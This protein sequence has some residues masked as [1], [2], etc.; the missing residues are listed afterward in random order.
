MAMH[1]SC[2]GRQDWKGA[3]V[4]P[5]GQSVDQSV[6]E[7]C[8]VVGE[9]WQIKLAVSLCLAG[10]GSQRGMHVDVDVVHRTGLLC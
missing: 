3:W 6:S 7:V 1:S 2:Q 4:C 9:L 5:A 8:P 10:K